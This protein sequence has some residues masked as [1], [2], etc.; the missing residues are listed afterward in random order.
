MTAEYIWPFWW[1]GLAIAGVA[2]A[3][4]VLTGRFLSVTRCY[5]GVC[6]LFSRLRFFQSP[7]IGGA[8]GFR[9]FFA[10]G[11][12]AG[13]ALAALTT[14]GWQPTWVLGKFD[15]IWGQS[16]ALKALVLFVGG[17]FWGYGSRLAKGCTAGNSI[18]GLA[19]GSLASLIAT[20][21]F[22]VAGMAVTFLLSAIS[23]V[24]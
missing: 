12:I 19:K 24:N 6:A 15:Q 16:L 4:V 1:G 9:T 17:F 8:L 23:G 20:C 21:G 3:V 2:I 11:I 7:D 18:S 13:G 10:V 22:L 5:A 14:T